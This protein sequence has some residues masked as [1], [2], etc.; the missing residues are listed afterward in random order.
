MCYTYYCIIYLLALDGKPLTTNLFSDLGTLQEIYNLW[1]KY[2]W[3]QNKNLTKTYNLNV[4]SI[5]E[6]IYIH[7]CLILDKC[8]HEICI[9]SLAKD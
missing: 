1:P 3:K 8:N 9:L 6:Y 2:F 4:Y 5:I 7:L